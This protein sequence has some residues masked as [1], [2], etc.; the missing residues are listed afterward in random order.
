MTK[1]I[2]VEDELTYQ[3]RI[4]E[5]IENLIKNKTDY[6]IE[7]YD[8]YNGSL[9][10]AI[11]EECIRKIYILDIELK[12]TKSGINIAKEIRKNDT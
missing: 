2:I 11:D 7:I 10:Q 3:N 1:F 6:T 8:K 4:K 5:V 9:K 12:G